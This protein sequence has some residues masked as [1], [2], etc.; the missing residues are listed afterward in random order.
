MT[1]RQKTLFPVLAAF[2]TADAFFMTKINMRLLVFRL[3]GM[4]DIHSWLFSLFRG[5]YKCPNMQLNVPGVGA[6]G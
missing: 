4:D 3:K 2:M 1:S 5:V 6:K